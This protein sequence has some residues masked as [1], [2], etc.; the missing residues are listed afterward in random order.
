MWLCWCGCCGC[1]T[2]Q[3]SCVFVSTTPTSSLTCQGTKY[4]DACT[5]VQACMPRCSVSRFSTSSI[6]QA[7]IYH[8]QAVVYHE[9]AV[10][11]HCL[12]I[13]HSGG[14]VL[15]HPWAFSSVHKSTQQAAADTKH[16]DI[17]PHTRHVCA[18]VCEADAFT[19]GVMFSHSPCLQQHSKKLLVHLKHKQ[20]YKNAPREDCSKWNP[21]SPGIRSQSGSGTPR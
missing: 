11:Y 8:E 18:H 20:K 4:I 5:L 15:R 14:L 2:K 12:V 16:M 13:Y 21:C 17:L 3:H 10:I 9:Q 7:V 1:G 6:E 19:A